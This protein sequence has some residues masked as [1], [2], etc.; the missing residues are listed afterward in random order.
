MLDAFTSLYYNNILKIRVKIKYTATVKTSMI[1]NN[2]QATIM[3]TINCA[4]V[5]LIYDDF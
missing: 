3:N 1:Q 5:P 4:N 2:N